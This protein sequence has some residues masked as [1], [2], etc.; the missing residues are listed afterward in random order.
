M[1]GRDAEMRLQPGKTV[2]NLRLAIQIIRDRPL[3]DGGAE[4][5]AGWS[6][7]SGAA[8]FIPVE[9]QAAFRIDT[10]VDRN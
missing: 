1:L 5:P 3:Y 6:N 9:Q 7:D 4:T 8:A 2:S 10:P